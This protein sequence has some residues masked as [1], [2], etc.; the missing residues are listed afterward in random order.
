MLHL[1]L[2]STRTNLAFVVWCCLLLV[3]ASA[4]VFRTDHRSRTGLSPWSVA[5]GRVVLRD[6]SMCTAT[7][8]HPSFAVTAAACV[9]QRG[10][11]SSLNASNVVGIMFGNASVPIMTDVARVILQRS[12][13]P[14]PSYNYLLL[15]LSS[16]VTTLAPLAVPGD[17]GCPIIP[18]QRR[19]VVNVTCVQFAAPDFVSAPVAQAAC[20]L[21]V[22]SS[23]ILDATHGCDTSVRGSIGAPLVTSSSAVCLAA[24]HVPGPIESAMGNATADYIVAAWTLQNANVALLLT[25]LRAHL[26]DLTTSSTMQTS[27]DNN[28]A[29]WVGV[30]VCMGAVGAVLCGLALLLFRTRYVNVQ[31]LPTPPPACPS[32]PPPRTFWHS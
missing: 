32:R 19:A 16:P 2:L 30:Y 22:S 10:N 28:R 25:D 11:R 21:N 15:Q 8:V 29:T 23:A 24:L 7:L 13:F 27:Q 17:A 1:Q 6:G 31:S 4:T 14:P 9:F 3:S 18:P 12:S 5:V 20:P 26:R